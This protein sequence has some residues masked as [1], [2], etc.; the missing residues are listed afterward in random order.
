M[1]FENQ[2]KFLGVFGEEGVILNPIP[3]LLPQ[4]VLAM[5]RETDSRSHSVSFRLSQ[6]KNKAPT[7]QLVLWEF[8]E[9]PSDRPSEMNVCSRMAGDGELLA[10]GKRT[11]CLLNTLCRSRVLLKPEF[12]PYALGTQIQAGRWG[13]RRGEGR[14][15]RPRDDGKCITVNNSAGH[16]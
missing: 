15:A 13:S 4:T 6:N 8:M 2:R 12:R 7:L 11:T 16:T 3:Y 5:G 9:P 10:S 14:R 1:N